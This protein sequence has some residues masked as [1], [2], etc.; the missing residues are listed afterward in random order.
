MR[1]MRILLAGGLAPAKF[2]KLTKELESLLVKEDIKAIVTQVNTFEV[3]DFSP[4]EESQDVI[5]L[6][7]PGKIDSKIPVVDGMGLLYAWMDRNKMLKELA[8]IGV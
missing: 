6:A 5:L 4:F 2:L 1:E 7:G 8:A 3:K